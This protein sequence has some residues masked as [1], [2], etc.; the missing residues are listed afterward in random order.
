SRTR[1]APSPDRR[2]RPPRARAACPA[3]RPGERARGSPTRPPNRLRPRTADRPS[4]RRPPRWPRAATAATA[5]PAGPGA[6]PPPR[7]P[8]PPLHL[9]RQ[10][11]LAQQ[12]VRVLA[13]QVAE[14]PWLALTRAARPV[15]PAPP[16]LLVQTPQQRRR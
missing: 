4:A 10:P 9:P 14:R 16:P 13:S 3:A 1:A 6:P 11:R 15:S 5:D 7:A 12:L 2:D 8:P